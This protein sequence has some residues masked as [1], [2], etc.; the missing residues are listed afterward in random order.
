ML[1]IEAN[2][3]AWSSCYS[4]TFCSSVWGAGGQEKVQG[5]PPCRWVCTPRHTAYWQ[6][7]S[8]LACDLAHHAAKHEWQ[9]VVSK[10]N[11]SFSVHY[12]WKDW[13]E[14]RYSQPTIPLGSISGESTNN[15]WKK[16]FFNVTLLLTG[17]MYSGLQW[18]P[19]YWTCTDFF[20][21]ITP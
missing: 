9:L 3:L 1:K 18:L 13:G 14:K 5:G 11:K 17:T 19:L 4:S 8:D 10:A 21:V 2:R 15:R 20:L 7:T 12:Q 16:A 6:S